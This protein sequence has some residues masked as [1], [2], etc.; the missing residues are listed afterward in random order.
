MILNIYQWNIHHL[1]RQDESVGIYKLLCFGQKREFG[2]LSCSVLVHFSEVGKYSRK[3]RFLNIIIRHSLNTKR[4]SAL[5]N[6]NGPK[7]RMISLQKIILCIHI[8]SFERDLKL[9]SFNFII[10]TTKITI[11]IKFIV[12]LSLSVISRL[13]R[14][15]YLLNFFCFFLKDG[16]N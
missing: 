1:S 8:A 15:L 16:P 14:F 11:N 2:T 10:N 3:T 12:I 4:F 13:I 5:H 6:W 9:S 7:I